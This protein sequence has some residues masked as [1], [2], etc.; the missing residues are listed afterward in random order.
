[1]LDKA[2]MLFQRAEYRQAVPALERAQHL[3][4]EDTLVALLLADAYTRGSDPQAVE[5]NPQPYEKAFA[6]LERL[7]ARDPGNLLAR[8]KRAELRSVVT[9]FAQVLP[10]HEENLLLA[11]GGPFEPWALLRLARLHNAR[12]HRQEAKHY[13]QRLIEQEPLYT[14]IACQELA[15]SHYFGG[16]LP[17]AITCRELNQTRPRTCCLPAHH[18]LD[19][20]DCLALNIE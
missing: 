8:I 20:L 12:G 7:I 17:A 3:V 13:Y 10:E 11:Q 6:V 15:V 14:G 19:L 18:H 2:K 9:P 4:P 1:M 16:D 5:A